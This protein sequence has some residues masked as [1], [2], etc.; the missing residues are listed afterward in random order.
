MD[1]PNQE[2]IEAA[3]REIESDQNV[4]EVNND[5]A[6][7]EIGRFATVRFICS[8]NTVVYRF[9][10]WKTDDVDDDGN[11]LVALKNIINNFNQILPTKQSEFK[12][13]FAT[14]GL[15]RYVFPKTMFPV[16]KDVQEE[17]LIVTLENNINDYIRAAKL[18]NLRIDISPAD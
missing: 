16:A 13:F 18:K 12:D 14:V 2:A 4:V 1:T 11:K 10:M 9:D 15:I 6:P 5:S 17:S 8:K 3:V 7:V